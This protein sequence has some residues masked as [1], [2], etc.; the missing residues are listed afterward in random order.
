M[1]HGILKLLREAG[2]LKQITRRGWSSKADIPRPESVADHSYRVCLAAVILG[3]LLH[4]DTLRCA[5]IALIHDLAESTIGDITP[6]EVGEGFDKRAS[7]EAVMEAILQNLP[8]GIRNLYLDAWREWVEN[9]SEEARLVY[10][11]DALEMALQ[12]EEYTLDGFD[13]ERLS[14]FKRSASLRIK[15]DLARRLLEALG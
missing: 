2:R 6:E 1:E 9:K 15:S 11:M 3:D 13:R 5:R 12:A 8:E 4:L 14:I 7:E 10:E